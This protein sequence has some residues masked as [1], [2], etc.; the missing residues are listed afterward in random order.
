M[1]K[2]MAAWLPD[3]VMTLCPRLDRAALVLERVSN[4]GSTSKMDASI[5][6]PH[7]RNLMKSANFIHYHRVILSKPH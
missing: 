1:Q 3:D 2:A 4:E 7:I 5:S 6:A